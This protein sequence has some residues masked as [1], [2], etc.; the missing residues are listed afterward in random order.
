MPQPPRLG[1]YRHTPGLELARGAD[2]QLRPTRVRRR[3][4]FRGLVVM[5]YGVLTP[6]V[7]LAVTLLFQRTRND[8]FLPRH[9]GE[10][11]VPA[12]PSLEN[13][14]FGAG[15]PELVLAGALTGFLLWNHL[16][17]LRVPPD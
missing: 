17:K 11:A 16:W 10:Q 5:A 15:L 3:F 7:G 4:P 14:L 8:R 13:V 12:A 2:G 9:Y 1:Q 6:L